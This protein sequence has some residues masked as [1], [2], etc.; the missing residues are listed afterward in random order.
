MTDATNKFYGRTT[1]AAQEEGKKW[2]GGKFIKELKVTR[3]AGEKSIEAEGATAE[4]ALQAVK[5][6]IPHD[7]FDIR[8]A[9]VIDMAN[10]G[11]IEIDAH[12]K[13]DATLQWVRKCPQHA[14]LIS[15]DCKVEPK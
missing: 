4:G 9:E 5:R 15:L 13:T 3:A 1:E 6:N 2:N 12:T 10:G 11:V 14:T 7:A 8:P